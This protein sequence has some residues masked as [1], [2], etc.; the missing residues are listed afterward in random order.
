M[1][2]ILDIKIK[3]SITSEIDPQIP[4]LCNK[5]FDGV[6]R[7]YFSNLKS[8]TSLPFFMSKKFI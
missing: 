2:Y 8:K 5:I 7:K 3:S 1:E 6:L 4:G